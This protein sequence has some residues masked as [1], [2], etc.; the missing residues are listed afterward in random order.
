MNG[1]D[2]GEKFKFPHLTPR[3]IDICKRLDNFY[4]Q[5]RFRPLKPQP[6][7]IFI[8]AIYA[9][10][11]GLRNNPDWISQVANSLRELLYPIWTE[12]R[13]C[14][15]KSDLIKK[16]LK[17]KG[18]LLIEDVFDEIEEVY[19]KLNDLA[20]HGV[21]LKIFSEEEFMNFGEQDFEKLVDQFEKSMFSAFSLTLDIFRQIDNLLL[22]SISKQKDTSQLRK[23]IK[24]LIRNNPSREYFFFKADEQWLDW[25]WEN[26]LLDIVNQKRKKSNQFSYIP[27][28][29][30]LV[31]MAQK[32]PDKVVNIMLSI[33]ISPDSFYPEL[34]D[35]FLMICNSLPADQLTR[36]VKKIR[37]EQWIPLMA[38]FYQWEIVYEK[39]FETLAQAKDYESLLI[40]A[41][42]V[43]SVRTKEE[44]GEVQRDG[45][46]PNPFYINNLSHTKVFE[47]LIKVENEYTEKAFALTVKVMRKLLSLWKNEN[48]KVNGNNGFKNYDGFMLLD[49]DLFTLQLSQKDLLSI[50]DH[51]RE[52]LAVIVVLARRLIGEKCERNVKNAYRIFKQYIGNFYDDASPLPDNRLIWRLRLFVMSLL[53]EVFKDELK[54]SFF[55]LFSFGHNY[56]Q[57][58]SGTEYL[59]ALSA[60]FFVLSNTEKRDFVNKVIE[61]FAKREQ[62]NESEMR[63]CQIAEG[64]KILS[65]ISDHLT[66]KEKK[67]AEKEGF[68]INK[69]YKPKPSISGIQGGFVKP[70]GPITPEEFNK[71]PIIEI[72]QNLRNE[73]SPAKLKEKYKKDDDFLRPKNAEGVENLLLNDIPK[74]LQDYVSNANLFFEKNTLHPHYTYSFLRGIQEAIKNNREPAFKINWDGII[75]MFL[76]I[77][78]VGEKEGFKRIRREEDYHW[79]GRWNTVHLAITDVLQELLNERDGYVVVDFDKY[80]TEIFSILKYLLSNPDPAPADEEIETAKIKIKSSGKEDYRVSN[81]LTIAI[82][83]VRGRAFE[84][85]VSFIYQD[86]KQFKKDKKINIAYDVK[87]LYENVLKNENTRALMFMFGHFL[88]LFYFKDRE[89]IR[90]LLH[91]IF[92]FTPEKHCLFTAAWEGYLLNDLYEEIFFDPEIQNLYRRSLRLTDKDYPQQ[93]EHFKDPK[94]GLASHLALAYMHYNKFGF[95]HTLFEEFW[96]MQDP[97]LHAKFIGFL[98][99]SFV[100]SENPNAIKLFEKN[101]ESKKRLRDFWDWMI[102]NYNELRPFMEFGLWI[103][104]EK[105]IFEPAWLA[106]RVKKTL[107]KTKGAI[108]WDHGLLKSLEKLSKEAPVETLEI[109][110]YFLLE[111]R[112]HGN[113]PR[114]HFYLEREWIK[115]LTILYQH[116]ETKYN[117]Y[118]LIDQLIREGGRLFWELKNIVND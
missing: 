117:T 11:K 97:E 32:V 14:Q 101:P 42:A 6:S 102:N 49:I 41:E 3:Q 45:F 114:R 8:G 103:N 17:E 44:M 104:I 81:P 53:P 37:D 108:N 38:S 105:D 109:A 111:G 86:S 2:F 64:S 54:K 26:G 82:N 23:E 70:Q 15:N 88:P 31:R 1:I 98:G 40:L 113:T 25:L 118:L 10:Q 7:E 48:Q 22:S 77:K 21:E 59:K 84:A 80:R 12:V 73:W 106:E 75:S 24:R 94:E 112:V 69:N 63:G 76:A 87:E 100:S 56:N 29:N 57:L 91:Q 99:R 61:Y 115:A 67:I 107:E 5:N 33:S 62:E 92:P 9:M 18:Y 43:L 93:Q 68:K 89:W 46:K 50:K 79:L 28:L 30:Y 34:I 66:K 4:K 78:E 20:H 35:K 52:L 85:F 16:K 110:R 71:L 60:G 58:I 39:M 90:G 19:G 96:K 83:S 51:I 36:V 95:G 65:V 27:E 55:R 72:V 47:N 116:P 13:R 74:R